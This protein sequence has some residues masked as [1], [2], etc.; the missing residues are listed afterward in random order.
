MMLDLA[1]EEN[2]L[3]VFNLVEQIPSHTVYITTTLTHTSTWFKDPFPV[4]TMHNPNL[5][6]ENQ[7]LWPLL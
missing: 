6:S 7:T 1:T 2:V 5:T 4:V 3:S